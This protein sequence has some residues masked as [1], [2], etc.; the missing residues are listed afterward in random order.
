VKRSILACKDFG[1][2]IASAL[3]DAREAMELLFGAVIVL[4]AYEI[5]SQGHYL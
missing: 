4:P 1:T 3:N 5:T 2:P